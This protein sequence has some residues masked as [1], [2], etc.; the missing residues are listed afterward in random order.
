MVAMRD[1]RRSFQAD[2]GCVAK[3]EMAWQLTRFAMTPCRAPVTRFQPMNRR[4]APAS[5][6][7]TRYVI[8]LGLGLFLGQ[9]VSL[10]AQRGDGSWLGF[11]AAT[12]FVL[13]ASASFVLF[14]LGPQRPVPSA[15]RS[16]QIHALVG[17]IGAGL[18]LS[19]QAVEF[20]A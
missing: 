6:S 16:R 8:A 9:A 10:M 3:P 12:V 4:T 14:V 17:V 2:S 20:L 11:I 13:S 1:M 18:L 15:V 5:P 7:H 19:L